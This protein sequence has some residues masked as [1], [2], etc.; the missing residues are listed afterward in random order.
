[1]FSLEEGSLEVDVVKGKM[2]IGT[3]LAG[4]TEARATGCWTVC[5]LFILLTVLESLQNPSS[6]ALIECAILLP[7]DRQDPTSLN[8][9]LWSDFSQV[10]QIKDIVLQPRLVLD[11]FGLRKLLLVSSLVR[12]ADFLSRAI[13]SGQ[14]R[15]IRPFTQDG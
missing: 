5:L 2:V 1:M 13:R 4:Q 11:T 15:L 10:D 14:E 3:E 8:E 7:L 12:R 9:V 6:L